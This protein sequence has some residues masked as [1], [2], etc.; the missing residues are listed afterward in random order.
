MKNYFISLTCVVFVITGINAQERN[1]RV[2]LDRGRL[3][4]TFYHSQ[5][6]E[7]VSDWRRVTYGLDWPGFNAEEV[8]QS[9][10]GGNSYLVSGGFYLTAKTDSG[11]VWG[12]ADFARNV[13]SNN[14][15]AW[16]GDNF[17]YLVSKHEKRWKNGENYW[18]AANP[19]EA[20]E[21]IDSEWG[22]NGAWFL[23]DDNQAI[24]ATV[25]RTVRQWSGSRADE[26]YLIVEYTVTNFL[27]RDPLNGVYLMFS[28]ALSPNHRGWRLTNPNLT[29]GAR[30][31]IGKWQPDEW[32]ISTYAGDYTSS[33]GIDETFDPYDFVTYDPVNDRNVITNEFVAPGFV[34]IKFLEIPADTNGVSKINGFA[35]STGAPS[36][37]SG[38]FEN[39]L[40]LDDKYDAMADPSLLTRAF[41]N[42]SDPQMGDGRLYANFSLGP[43]NIPRRD[44]IKIVLAEFVGGV[45][46]E[47]TR[48]NQ[49]SVA[50]IKAAGDSAVQY[51]SDRV[52]FNYEN[53]YRVPMPPPAPDFS[54]TPVTVAGELGNIIRFSN[55]PELVPDPHQ[56]VADLAGYRIYRSSFLP[57]GPWEQI[58]EIPKGD[59]QFFNS[60][61]QAYVFTDDNVA[62]GFGYYYA[63]T[64]FDT[65]HDAWAINPAVAVPPL[66]SSIF[67]NRSKTS[68]QTTLSPSQSD[69]SNVQVVPNP[70]YRSSGFSEPGRE[71]D[72][73]FVFLPQRCTIRILTVRG[74]LVKTIRH[75]N[76]NSGVAVW[77]QISDFG[78]YV[79]SGMYFYV[80]ENDNGDVERGKFAIVN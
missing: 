22:I 35:W 13:N 19:N 27:R 73:Q 11:T 20:E 33:P 41:T 21:I 26:D 62:L 67:A 51:L 18:L 16:E 47:K 9:I 10:G 15:V 38:P 61:S 50:E 28:W 5:E 46:F 30:N 80:I 54:V 49:L 45:P 17:R 53:N 75:D 4:H 32:L 58:A 57:F 2:T 43:F 23:P 68:F 8:R 24:P 3:W 79:K 36:Q 77:N 52:S 78:Q 76:P 12:W 64:S 74:D 42:D 1:F 60:D 31:T 66:E 65:G 39:V 14:M 7:P 48:G 6:C 37:D 72:I 56:G 44:S 34:G 25:K 40:G 59:P 63:V 55:A 29:D 71:R 70:F 69:I